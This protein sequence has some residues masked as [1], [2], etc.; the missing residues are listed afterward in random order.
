MLALHSRVERAS[1]AWISHD[2]V[3]SQEDASGLYD[4]QPCTDEDAEV[5][6][7][8]VSDSYQ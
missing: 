8:L 5:K 2:F 4:W 3:E 7:Q 6:R 1:V